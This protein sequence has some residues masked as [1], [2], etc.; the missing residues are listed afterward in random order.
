[1]EKKHTGDVLV[2]EK[3]TKGNSA[4]CR[5]V[6]IYYVNV[7]GYKSKRKSIKQL[8]EECNIDILLLSEA[9]LYSKTTVKIEGF[10]VFPAVRPKNCSRGLLVAIKHGLCSAVMIERGENAEFI[11]IKAALGA[12]QIRIILAYGPQEGSSMQDIDDLFTQISIQVN[13]AILSGNSVMLVGDFNAKL[14]KGLIKGDVH[15]IS[16]NGKKFQ[17]VLQFF[18]MVAVNSLS[19][20]NGVFTRV[21]NN[22][23]DEKPVLDYVC[24]TKDNS[25]LLLTMYEKKMYT[26]WRKLKRGKKYTDHNVILL[27]MKLDTVLHKVGNQNRK[28]I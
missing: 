12:K 21:N 15:D 8:P 11:T 24:I 17:S 28:T 7:N 2:G 6:G 25:D 20:C 5:S 22:N 1:M 18:Y 9:K 26:P 10:Q 14:G 23:P 4:S 19:L 27:T 13:R 3:S 16:A